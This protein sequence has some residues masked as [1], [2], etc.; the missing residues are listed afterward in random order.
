MKIIEIQERFWSW[1]YRINKETPIFG[2]LI[3]F[4]IMSPLFVCVEIFGGLWG[5]IYGYFILLPIMLSKVFF[6]KYP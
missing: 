5:S 1:Y 4:I 3:W 2:F 6:S